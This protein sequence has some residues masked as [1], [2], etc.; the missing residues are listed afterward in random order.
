[1]IAGPSDGGDHD[2]DD[3]S[4]DNDRR[5]SDG[6]P[7]ATALLLGTIVICPRCSVPVAFDLEIAGW[8]RVPAGG[9]RRTRW[10]AWAGRSG[11]LC[12]GATI[13]VALAGGWIVRIRVP[14]GFE[15]Q[16]LPLDA[17]PNDDQRATLNVI[18]GRMET[19]AHVMRLAAP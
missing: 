1:V 13:R 7:L 15:V 2:D 9:L 16:R 18:Y 19:L 4:H 10:L 8:V 11:L 14:S 12:P 6:Y 5:S 3:D 17:E